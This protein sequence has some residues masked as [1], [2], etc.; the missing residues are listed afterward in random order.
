MIG[1][2]T[3]EIDL[4]NGTWKVYINGGADV[5][6]T[7]DTNHL[8]GFDRYQATFQQFSNGD[9]IDVD[10]IS[11][12]V[13]SN[14]GTVTLEP[15]T[16][17]YTTSQDGETILHE[18]LADIFHTNGNL[19]AKFANISGQSDWNWTNNVQF[20]GAEAPLVQSTETLVGTN[21]SAVTSAWLANGAASVTLPDGTR[22]L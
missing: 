16:G 6:G 7:F 18:N 1:N 2:L 8:K 15:A 13:T 22:R 9:Y 10:E 4:A 17:Y 14:S 12:D 20:V 5:L 21:A 19:L 11:V 3:L